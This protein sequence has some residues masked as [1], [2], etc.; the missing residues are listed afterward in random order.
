MINDLQQ[1][2]TYIEK[3]LNKQLNPSRICDFNEKLI[4]YMIDALYILGFIIFVDNEIFYRLPNFCTCPIN[5]FYLYEEPK[6]IHN[7]IKEKIKN[8]KKILQEY[9]QIYMNT[10]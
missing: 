7:I 2:N 9:I 1:L 10:T 4:Y 8:P 6:E 3:I 5:I